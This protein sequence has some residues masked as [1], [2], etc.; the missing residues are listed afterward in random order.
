MI[1]WGAV[2]EVDLSMPRLAFGCGSNSESGLHLWRAPLGAA[3][4]LCG[5]AKASTSPFP[6]R[7]VLES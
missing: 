7:G 5:A 1:C 3:R 2:C 4:A 6:G